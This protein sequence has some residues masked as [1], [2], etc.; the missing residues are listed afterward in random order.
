MDDVDVADAAGAV[1][2]FLADY[3]DDAGAEGY[4]VGVSGGVDSAVAATLAARAVGPEN[5]LGLVMPGE[6]SDPS[7]VADA[8]DRCDS[9][10]I[11]WREVDVSG[12]V[13]DCRDAAGA[14]LDL[15][16]EAVGNARARVRMVLWYQAANAR[17]LL[18]LG[19]DNRSEVR[20]GYFTKHGDGAT[21]VRAL[22]DLY[23]TEVYDLARLL[24]LP[25]TFLEK[26]PT[27]G[28]WEGQTDREEIGVPYETVDP[29][30]FSLYEADRSVAETV[31]AVDADRET[32]ERL[33]EMVEATEH[34]RTPPPSP[35]LR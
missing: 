14:D 30:L 35:G 26:E 6:P 24:D 13:A 20:L 34:K 5:V 28:L 9:L 8:R 11:R 18:V 27:A 21:D 17:D 2:E 23:K 22:A 15:G 32:V 16:P 1:R 25:E 4:V 31:A 10:G 19:A 29:V 12:I 7:N 33:R 3:R